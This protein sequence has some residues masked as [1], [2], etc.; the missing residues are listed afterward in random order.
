MRK[1]SAR[2]RRDRRR[3]RQN[4]DADG[5]EVC[6]QGMRCAGR[7]RTRRSGFWVSLERSSGTP[8]LW[9]RQCVRRT[10]HR[11]SISLKRGTNRGKGI[12]GNVDGM[13]VAIGTEAFVRDEGFTPRRVTLRMR[14]GSVRM[15]RQLRVVGIQGAARAG[16][17]CSGIA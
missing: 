14:N 5:R 1:R 9:H 3:V 7:H 13:H 10:G 11:L 6:V 4:R 16:M 8:G 2:G 17:S 12:A 15:E